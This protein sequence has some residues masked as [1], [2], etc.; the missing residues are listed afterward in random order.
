M[1][2]FIRIVIG[3]VALLAAICIGVFVALWIYLG[4]FNTA[5][6]SIVFFLQIPRSAPLVQ[7]IVHEADNP[8]V[9]EEF[10]VSLR[11]L[12]SFFLDTEPAS[13]TD[14]KTELTAQSGK[15][16]ID[17]PV[18]LELYEY[19]DDGSQVLME[20]IE[21]W[22]EAS[23][24][25]PPDEIYPIAYRWLPSGK[26]IARLYFPENTDLSKKMTVELVVGYSGGKSI[27]CDY[28]SF[29]TF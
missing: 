3:L 17:F 4:S 5:V 7:E 21:M 2:L 16:V 23:R 12:Y 6:G 15:I 18:R 14:D 8:V 1:K 20:T 22:P 26:Y 27:N 9:D 24:G 28:L 29:F 25:W 11:C 10:E 19:A 13:T